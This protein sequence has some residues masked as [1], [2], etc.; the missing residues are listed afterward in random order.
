M[1]RLSHTLHAM[2]VAAVFMLAGIDAAWA[3]GTI[4]LDEVMAQLKDDGKLIGEI[5][6]AL[7][8]QNLKADAIICVGARFGGHWA[9][10]GGARSIPYACD[11][12]TRKLSVDG[13]LR[14]YDERGAE[15]DMSDEQAPDLAFDYKQ[16]DL[17]W[18]WQ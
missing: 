15:I 3:P 17:T 1:R 16:T 7:K 8:A 2:L 12:G 5:E 4:T 6:D 14:L 11:I 9:E 18:T 13:T 10:L